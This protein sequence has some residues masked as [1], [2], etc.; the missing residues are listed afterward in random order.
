MPQPAPANTYLMIQH[1]HLSWSSCT[2]S[3]PGPAVGNLSKTNLL[4]HRVTSG[5][6]IEV[7]YDGS[8]SPSQIFHTISRCSFSRQTVEAI[9]DDWFSCHDTEVYTLNGKRA[10][11]LKT[12]MF[13][14]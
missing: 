2:T 11:C 1:Y 9:S 14:I 8:L 12:V 13:N 10:V 4:Q 7:P 3:C 6:S 5:R